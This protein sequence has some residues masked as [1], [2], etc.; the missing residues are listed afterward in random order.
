MLGPCL[1]WMDRRAGLARDATHMAAKI[2][3][4][5]GVLGSDQKAMRFHQPVS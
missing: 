4:L 5:K 2:G 3:W 1:I